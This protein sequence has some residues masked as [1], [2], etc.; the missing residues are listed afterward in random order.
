MLQ[1]KDQ[2][3]DEPWA[4]RLKMPDGDTDT[5]LRGVKCPAC[6]SEQLYLGAGN[7]VTCAMLSCPNPDYTAALTD[8][9]QAECNRARLSEARY[10]ENYFD[11]EAFYPDEWQRRIAELQQLMKGRE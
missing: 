4:K 2:P 11:G 5:Y 3:V 1:P 9:I 6:G 10:V 8:R 7:Y